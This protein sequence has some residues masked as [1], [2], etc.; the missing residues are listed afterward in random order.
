MPSIILKLVKSLK[1]RLLMKNHILSSI[2][3]IIIAI[4]LIDWLRARL[5]E[6]KKTFISEF[7]HS[8]S[9]RHAPKILPFAYI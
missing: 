2:L 5:T 4:G 3:Y 6:K 1:I 9:V 7:Y 8:L